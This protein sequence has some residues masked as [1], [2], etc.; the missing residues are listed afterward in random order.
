MRSILDRPIW[1][2]V[3]VKS[4]AVL[5]RLPFS[6]LFGVVA[7]DAPDQGIR[8]GLRWLPTRPDISAL[9]TENSVLYSSI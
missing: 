5:K 6:R 9:T 1:V 3:P 7:W 2:E 4:E 8:P